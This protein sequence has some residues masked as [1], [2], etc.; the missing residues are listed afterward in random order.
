MIFDTPIFQFIQKNPL[1]ATG[2]GL[3][4]AA[5]LSYFTKDLPMGLWKIIK[6]QF[7]VSI[8][9]PSNENS[10]KA[11]THWLEDNGKTKFFRTLR[12]RNGKISVGL[13]KQYFI[14]HYRIWW[15]DRE[16][17]DKPMESNVEEL[18]V[19][20]FT[21]NQDVVRRFIISA[22][23]EIE[24]NDRI[25]I[26][27]S[28]NNY[29]DFSRVQD[30]KKLDT[31][32]LSE[33]SKNEIIHHL[34][35]FYASAAWYKTGGIPFRTG[36]CFHGP[37]GTGKTSLV[38]ALASHFGLDIYVLGLNSQSDG[39]IRPLFASL[40][41]K[42]LILIEDIDTIHSTNTRIK[43][44]HEKTTN[45]LTL[46]GLLNAIDG[47]VESNGRV[48]IMT[49]NHIENLDPALIR[50]GRCDKTIELSYLND[51]TFRLAFKRFYPLF[52]IPDHIKWPP[53]VTPAV[54]QTYVLQNK[55]TPEKLLQILTEK[56]QDQKLDTA[57]VYQLGL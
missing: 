52:Q 19:G 42:C 27:F 4:S 14:H 35:T 26:Y 12:L 24:N 1:L 36:L 53:T 50:P 29:W 39:S 3:W 54:L 47:I 9:I 6:K 57:N 30:K 56:E 45:G 28:E 40:P 34:T 48:L 8:E 25:S 55:N 41:D 32:M 11:V 31:V 51:E 17:L 7:T 21:R 38:K 18:S 49:T 5:M 10:F 2:L 33:K 37:P 16:R 46:G 22:K 43:N 15:I 44:N 13:G 20:C 23:N